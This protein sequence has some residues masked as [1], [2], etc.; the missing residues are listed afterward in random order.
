MACSPDG[1]YCVVACTEKIYIWQVRNELYHQQALY[2]AFQC[3][4][5]NIVFNSVAMQ[6]MVTQSSRSYSGYLR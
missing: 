2:E 4:T 3:C 1:V 6:L 5:H